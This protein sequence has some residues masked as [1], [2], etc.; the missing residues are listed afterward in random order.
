MKSRHIAGITAALAV[1]AT[2]SSALPAEAASTVRIYRVYYDSPGSDNRSNTSLNAE[3]V[4]IIN[5]GSTP[6]SLTGWKL[7]DR[8]GYTYTFGSFRLGA[9]KTV[10]VHTG[11]GTDTTKNLYWGRRAYVWNNTGDTA[12]LRSSSGKSIDSCS[13]GRSGSSR[14]C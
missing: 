8:T 3:W 4:Q 1:A 14:Y 2:L 6:R 13:W 9:R 11:R 5:R 7:R 10:Y 12:Y